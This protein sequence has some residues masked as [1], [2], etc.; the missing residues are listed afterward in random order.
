MKSCSFCNQ[1]SQWLGKKKETYLYLC[2]KHFY[3]YA[4]NFD[5]C[6]VIKNG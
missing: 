1:N 2:Q 6:E 3:A 4:I 5:S